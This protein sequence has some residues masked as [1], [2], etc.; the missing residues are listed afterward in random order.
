MYAQITRRT[1]D[2]APQQEVRKRAARAFFPKLQQ[3]P[4]FV[5]FYLIA[6]EDGRTR[7]SSCG[8][9]AARPRRSR[10]SSRPGP[11]PWKRWRA[12]ATP[13]PRAR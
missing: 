5:A 1:P 10:P 12:D 2:R 3:A 9:T 13:A 11:T 4:G 8:R 6:E 7:R